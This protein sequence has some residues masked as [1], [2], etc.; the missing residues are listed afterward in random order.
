MYESSWDMFKRLKN[1]R[2][3]N[4]KKLLKNMICTNCKEKKTLKRKC[5]WHDIIT[6]FMYKYTENEAVNLLKEIENQDEIY[7]LIKKI[8]I[9]GNKK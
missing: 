2:C 7:S 8:D 3:I 6:C 5:F 1:L 9:K 4:F